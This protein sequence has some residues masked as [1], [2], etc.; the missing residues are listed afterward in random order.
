MICFLGHTVGKVWEDTTVKSSKQAFLDGLS[1]GAKNPVSK[2]HRLIVLHIGSEKGFVGESKLVFECKG[3][4]DYHESMNAQKFEKWFE[5]TIPRLEPN[6]VVVMDNA[7]YHSRRQEKI[8][9]T[10]WRKD[11]IQEWLSG[12]NIPYEMSDTKVLLLE[13]V[14]ARKEQYQTYVVDEMAKGAGIEI[15]R[16]PPYHC[17]LNPIELIWA[18]IKG[19]VA[20]KNT[21]F[22]MAD[23]KKL[24]EEGIE[25]ITA[26]KWSNCVQHVVKEEHKLYGLDD[27]IDKTVDSFIINVTDSS[28][29]SSE[30]QDSEDSEVSE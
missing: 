28:T 23:V 20:R 22:K 13:K 16:L 4:G 24:L 17:E 5:E 12:K 14:K 7:S 3:T 29:E 6:A 25:N 9:V 11:A 21:S 1:T 19:Y 15:L 10:S 30:F 8:P 2:G 27:S 18:D 26:E